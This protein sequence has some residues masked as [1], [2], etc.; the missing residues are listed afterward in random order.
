MH[1]KNSSYYYYFRAFWTS[2]PALSPAI[3]TLQ[4][5]Q[6]PIHRGISVPLGFSGREDGNESACNMGDP[7]LIPGLAR[8]PGEG[9]DNTLQYSCLGNPMDSGAWQARVRG[10]TKS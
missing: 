6:M 10:V 2:S 5:S 4:T 3:L 1:S 7:G 9:T 8:P